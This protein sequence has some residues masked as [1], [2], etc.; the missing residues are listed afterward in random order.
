MTQI[1]NITGA[2]SFAS[3]FIV[4]CSSSIEAGQT[5]LSAR[6]VGLEALDKFALAFLMNMTT[7][8]LLMY[9]VFQ[10]LTLANA[11]C[12]FATVAQRMGTLVKQLLAFDKDIL[13]VAPAAPP[14]PPP[15][16]PSPPPA[17]PSPPSPTPPTVRLMSQQPSPLLAL[18]ALSSPLMVHK[19]RDSLF[20][21]VGEPLFN[22]VRDA[23]AKSAEMA[24]EDLESRE[25]EANQKG[26]IQKMEE[27]LDRLV[28]QPRRKYKT[29]T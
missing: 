10:S 14:S 15:A 18:S 21:K 25:A 26:P 8:L 7:S 4:Q 22:T 13:G 9:Q 6:Y 5:T 19:N 17:P 27:K 28:N 2:L 16:P 1:N 3:N 24:R 11:N 20:W 23:F 29:Q 12:D